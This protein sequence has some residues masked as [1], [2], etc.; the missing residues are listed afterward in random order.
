MLG[1]VADDFTGASDAAS[2]LAQA[3][4]P[5]VLLNEIPDA[6]ARIGEDACAVVIALKTRTIPAEEAVRQSM[7][8]FHYLDRLGA[9]K[10]YFKY[11]STFDSTDKGNIGPVVDALLQ[12]YKEKYTV[13]CP[14]LPANGRVVKGGKLYVNGVLLQDSHMKDHPLTPMRESRIAALMGAQG[15]YA[16]LE[17][18]AQELCD[19]NT[20]KKIDAKATEWKKPFYVIPDY[21]EDL[22]GAQI[23]KLFAA[24]RVYT[25]GS[26][27]AGALGSFLYAKQPPSAD[28]AMLAGVNGKG[29]VLAGSCSAITLKQI[30]AFKQKGF[31][32]YAL[33]PEKLLAGEEC[34]QTIWEKVKDHQHEVL[35]YSSEAPEKI[36]KAQGA[37]AKIEATLSA[38]AHK[39]LQ[40][41]YT[42]FVVAGGETSGA[43]T[44]ALGFRS[45]Y[46]GES[47]ATGVPI[48]TPAESLNLRIV[49]KSGNFGQ[50]DFFERAL[51]MISL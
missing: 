33:S 22:H 11:C 23:V 21:Y 24:C 29:I 45:F 36:S 15:K 50:I 44:K 38:L 7:A 5:T 27:L 19:E 48:M 51:K 42:R 18:G 28:K 16:S 31:P 40:G 2:F 4:L 35:I 46:I 1:C 43:V 26:G 30:D 17:I 8:A 47:V 37:A 9:K 32:Y 39:A 10:L 6:R 49:L 25:G 41:G 3:G 20:I 12:T 14:S 13:I 34:A